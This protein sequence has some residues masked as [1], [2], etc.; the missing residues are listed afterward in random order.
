MLISPAAR[1]SSFRASF[2]RAKSAITRLGGLLSDL[3]LAPPCGPAQRSEGSGEPRPPSIRP[4]ESI[5]RLK[6]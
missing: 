3:R 1:L 4:G 2:I 6:S 5:V